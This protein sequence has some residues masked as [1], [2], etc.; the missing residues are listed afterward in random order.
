MPLE[1]TKYNE[2]LNSS[3]TIFNNTLKEIVKIYPNY[4]L[5]IEYE[6][7][8]INYKRNTSILQNT[9]ENIH[10]YFT[11]LVQNNDTISTDITNTDNKIKILTGENDSLMTQL[12][13]FKGSNNAASGELIN[14]EDLHNQTLV[15]NIL[16]LIIVGFFA[17]NIKRFT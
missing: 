1:P 16:L 15:Q 4:K 11:Q 9:K 2:L 14:A 8:I 6:P 5:N 3:Y 7:Y 12:N 10:K 13:N 17:V